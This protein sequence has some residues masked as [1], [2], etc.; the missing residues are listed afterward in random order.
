MRLNGVGGAITL[1]RQSAILPNST[2][3][4]SEVDHDL[5]IAGNETDEIDYG[6]GDT[7][8]HTNL[9]WQLQG[10]SGWSYRVTQARTY[11]GS[12][13][14]ATS[15]TVREYGYFYDGQARLTDVKAQLSG[16][17]ELP[18]PSGQARAAGR[19]SE[20][21]S[22]GTIL[23][24]HIDYDGKGYGLVRRVQGPNGQ[25]TSINYDSTFSQLPISEI[26]YTGGSCGQGGLATTFVFDRGIERVTTKIAPDGGATTVKYDV[27]GRVI[28]TD[29]PA[30]QPGM[31]A[32]AAAVRVDYLD[33]AP[34]RRIHVSTVDGPAGATVDRQHYRYIDSFGETLASLDEAGA[35]DASQGPVWTV[36]GAHRHYSGRRLSPL[37][38]VPTEADMALAAAAH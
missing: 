15:G 1:F 4:V 2:P 6:A 20:Q 29:Q 30:F 24:K 5:G 36:S 17:L 33:Q 28:E 21:S 23:L 38:N 8:I 27:F 25:C 11:Y 7:P 35:A 26:V 34:I 9:Q 16:T 37:N 13:T 22:D 19:P 31:S 18:G 32:A 14:A 12:G 3:I 10:S